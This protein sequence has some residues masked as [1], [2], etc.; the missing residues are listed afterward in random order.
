MSDAIVKKELSEDNLQLHCVR[1]GLLGLKC[2]KTQKNKTHM[3]IKGEKA[4]WWF[5]DARSADTCIAGDHKC[6]F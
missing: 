3:K 6:K 1:Y 5:D 4:I 2:I